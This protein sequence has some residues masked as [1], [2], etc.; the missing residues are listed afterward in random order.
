MFEKVDAKF[1]YGS[2]R[3]D[4]RVLSVSDQG[5]IADILESES[6]GLLGDLHQHGSPVDDSGRAK[7]D[8]RRQQDPL[9]REI[10]Q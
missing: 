3:I 2:F 7:L 1:G 5:T 4:H 10:R 8:Q 6:Q 9:H